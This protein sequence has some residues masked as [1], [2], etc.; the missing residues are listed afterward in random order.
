MAI[1]LWE[2]RRNLRW[3][4]AVS[5]TEGITPNS[6]NKPFMRFNEWKQARKKFK[7]KNQRF[8]L[9]ITYLNEWKYFRRHSI[10]LIIDP[11]N[12][13]FSE[14]GTSENRKPENC[15]FASRVLVPKSVDH[16]PKRPGY[17]TD[18][19]VQCVFDLQ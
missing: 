16:S 8:A 19:V 10:R 6:S 12:N 2:L 17:V 13:V 11:C 4:D 15:L 5:S 14:E 7:R 9:S 18:F 3:K 1:N